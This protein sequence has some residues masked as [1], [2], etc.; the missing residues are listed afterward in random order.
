MLCIAHGLPFSTIICLVL[1]FV[2][3]TLAQA[4]TF[5]S[6]VVFAVFPIVAFLDICHHMVTYFA[7]VFG[8]FRPLIHHLESLRCIVVWFSRVPTRLFDLDHYLLC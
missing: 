7:I 3:S 8:C 6:F 2:S 1:F 5:M 4:T